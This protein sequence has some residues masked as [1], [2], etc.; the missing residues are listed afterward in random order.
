MINRRFRLMRRPSGMPAADDFVLDE[1]QLPALEDGQFLIRNHYA[2]L[3]PAMRGWMDDR[4]SYL[5]PIPLGS[6]V[7]AS[8]VG[9]IVQSRNPDFPEGRWVFGQ[10]AIEDYS[11][12]NSQTAQLIDEHAMPSVTHYLSVLGVAGVTAYLALELAEPRPGH[13]VLVTGAAG[14][15]G[16]IVGQIAKIRGCRTIGIA[17][18]AAKCARL[19]ER[20]RYDAAIDYRGK[21]SQQL[22]EAIRTAIPDGID[23]H[24]EN[25]GGMILD[26]ALLQIN[27]KARVILCGLI[28]QY[29][30]PPAP[31]HNIWQL[32]VKGA[33]MEGFILTQ[34]WDRVP[35]ART[36]L[37]EWVNAGTLKVDEHI[38]EGIANAPPAFLRLFEGT[39]EGKMILKLA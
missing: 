18:G 20:Y 25:V 37:A 24:F 35:D 29:N 36:R 31:T 21:N 32:I 19:L 39:N 26:A 38:D 3:D 6:P 30:G 28:S 10:N 11:F 1:A 27:Q 4:P 5:P 13:T 23:I 7:R 9:V 17:G 16:S 12:G 15:V 8:T 2:S 14:A 33:R 34:H 22:D